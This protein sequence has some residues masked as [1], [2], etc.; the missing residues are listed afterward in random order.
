MKEVSMLALL[1]ITVAAVLADL[2]D[3][4]IPNGVIVTGLLWGGTY[5]VMARGIMGM[6][7]FLGGIMLPVLLFGVLYYFRM[8]GAGDIKL[9]CVAGGF[10]GPSSCFDCI[11]TAVLTGGMIALAVMLIHGSFC[12]RLFCFYDYISNYFKDRQWR[13]YMKETD[14]KSRFCFSIPILLGI[15]CRIGGII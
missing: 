4:R 1:C 13:P 5:Q 2:K 7:V 3:E 10:L 9:L 14:E 11:V 15:L 12:R 6:T 8:I